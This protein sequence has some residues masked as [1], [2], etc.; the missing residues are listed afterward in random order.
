MFTR[1]LQ[2][3]YAPIDDKWWHVDCGVRPLV[4]EVNKVP[5]LTTHSSCSGHPGP[6]GKVFDYYEIYSSYYSSIK[7][8]LGSTIKFGIHPHVYFEGGRIEALDYIEYIEDRLDQTTCQRDL[9][10]FTIRGKGYWEIKVDP[11]SRYTPKYLGYWELIANWERIRQFT[12]E[13][14]AGRRIVTQ[15]RSYL[16][17]KTQRRRWKSIKRLM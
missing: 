11:T 16:N 17:I 1:T 4:R 9:F 15:E 7:T 2:K 12:T 13:Y 6:E 10:C 14:N 5:G 3:L 8:K